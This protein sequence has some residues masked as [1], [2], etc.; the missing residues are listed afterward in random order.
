M[1]SKPLVSI[2]MPVYNGERFVRRAL[3]SLLAQ[4]H[5]NLELI[6]SDN[7]S[8][9]R[10]QAIC[11]EYAARD[12]RVCCYR[13]AA[14][15]GAV[16]NFNRVFELA[17]GD[18]FMWA[19]HHDLWDSAFVS[20]CLEVLRR[21]PQVVLCY[22]L[23]HAIDWESRFLRSAPDLIDTRR[24]LPAERFRRVIR[25]MDWF[26][27]TYGLFRADAVRRKMEA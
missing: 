2:G 14:N 1:G 9:D 26:I 10:T 5:E 27:A 3:D 11:L 21:E 25:D 4:D 23:S 13:N 24:L 19:S 15:L 8:E 22:P 6:T 18:Y 17:S 7:A 20:T 12:N 16:R